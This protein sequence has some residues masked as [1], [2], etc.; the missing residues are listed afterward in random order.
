MLVVATL[1]SAIASAQAPSPLR[2]TIQG[3]PRRSARPPKDKPASWK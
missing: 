3:S 2:E 1:A